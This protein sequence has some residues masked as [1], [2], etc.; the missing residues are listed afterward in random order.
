MWS[1]VDFRASFHYPDSSTSP[2]RR[3]LKVKN[4][5]PDTTL[6]LEAIKTCI[7]ELDLEGHG[8][9]LHMIAVGGWNGKHLDPLVSAKE[10]YEAF[11]S[12]LGD[13][14]DGFDW[15]LEGNDDMKSIYNTF[16]FECLDKMGEISRM[17][18]EGKDIWYRDR[19]RSYKNSLMKYLV[20]QMATSC[21]WH[22][23]NLI[24]TFM[25]LLTSAELLI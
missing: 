23:P 19:P 14:F 4:V 15:D 21:Q 16:T 11:D 10:W 7:R 25:A 20:T 17:A 13:V 18:H 8:N 9:V 2:H 12:Y 24:S 6:D 3:F 1:F 5:V 22:H